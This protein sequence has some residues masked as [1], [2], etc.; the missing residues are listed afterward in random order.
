MHSKE[1]HRWQHDH[2]FL[3][4]VHGH[5]ERRTRYVVYLTVV[6][7]FVEITAG[8]AFGSMAL[9]A[10]GWHMATHACALGI[11]VFAYIYARR[12]VDDRR[13]T[14][15]T[16]KVGVL[17]GFTSA[18]VLAIVALL[19]AAESAQRLYTPVSIHFNEAIAVAILGLLVNV[20]SA[21]L[22]KQHPHDPQEPADQHPHHDPNLRGAYFHVLADALTSLLAIFSLL[23]GKALGWIWMDPLMG[24]VG[25]LVISRWSYGLLQ[26]T[27]RVLL[28]SAVEPPVISTIR[29]AIEADADNRVA[30]LHVWRVGPRHLAAIVSV[31]T[32]YPR[33]P[34]HYKALLAKHQDLDHITVEVHGAPGEACLPIDEPMTQADSSDYPT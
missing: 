24:I 28:D 13:Y 32:H 6:T 4:D 20:A 8:V 30:D 26:E 21:W 17:G 27:G 15:G 3:T 19:V 10:D 29:H 31:V 34:G 22:L 14:F 25:A 16:G 7:M 5:G 18:I 9:L 12:H 11:T 2:R 23:V 33:P 1:L